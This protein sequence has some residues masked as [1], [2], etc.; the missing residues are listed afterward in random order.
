MRA[1]YASS[2]KGVCSRLRQ[3]Y[4]DLQ[5]VVAA[6][7]LVVHLMIG[8]I[9]VATAFVLDES[10]A[11]G[12]LAPDGHVLARGYSQARGSRARGRN[13]AADKATVP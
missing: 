4:L 11:A 1:H 7:A 5:Q 10:K 13:V 8:I 9:G 2:A 3:T 6:D 12:Q